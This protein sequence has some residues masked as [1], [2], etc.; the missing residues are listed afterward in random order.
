VASSTASCRTYSAPLG[1]PVA[2]PAPRIRLGQHDLAFI[3]A[4]P[5]NIQ[6]QPSPLGL[7]QLRR[8][9]APAARMLVGQ[10][11]AYEEAVGV[12]EGC[13]AS[14]MPWLPSGIVESIGRAPWPA[15]LTHISR[16]GPN[17]RAYSGGRNVRQ[18]VSSPRDWTG[19]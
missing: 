5:P 14:A 3:L 8:H 1:K 13:A 15:A 18:S 10:G 2:T 4:R 16:T 6:A 17:S 9:A 11:D 12:W 7:L 19:S